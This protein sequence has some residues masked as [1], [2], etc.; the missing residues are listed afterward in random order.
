MPDYNVPGP[1][2]YTADGTRTWP[3]WQAWYEAIAAKFNDLNEAVSVLCGGPDGVVANYL[4]GLTSGQVSAISPPSMSVF[5]AAGMFIADKQFFKIATSTS[6]TFT[7]PTVEDRIDTIVASGPDRAY[8]VYTGVEAS[9]P[10]APSVGDGE[11]LLAHVYLRPGMT[12]I[13][14]SDVTGEGFLTDQRTFTNA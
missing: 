10:S 13:H 7:A 5:I 3:E 8:V 11:V 4:H 14:E 6:P 9:T 1:N 12:E 2:P